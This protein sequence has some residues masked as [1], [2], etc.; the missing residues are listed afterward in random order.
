[1]KAIDYLGVGAELQLVFNLLRI[2]YTITQCTQLTVARAGPQI[3]LWF[4]R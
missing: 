3:F 2:N 4:A 1:M